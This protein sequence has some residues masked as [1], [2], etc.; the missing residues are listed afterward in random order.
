MEEKID[1]TDLSDEKRIITTYYDDEKTKI[2]KCYVADENIK[3]GLYEE[4]HENGKIALSLMCRDDKEEG[5]EVIETLYDE[6]G[7]PVSRIV[8]HDEDEDQYIADVLESRREGESDKE[9][10]QRVC[11]EHEAKEQE[12]RLKRELEESF[13]RAEEEYA[14][15]YRG[16]NDFDLFL[17]HAD[18]DPKVPLEIPSFSEFWAVRKK[19]V[20][21]IEKA[22]AEIAEAEARDQWMQQDENSLVVY[23]ED[24]LAKKLGL[25]I[26]NLSTKGKI[27][28]PPMIVPKAVS[29]QFPKAIK[30]TVTQN[31][32]RE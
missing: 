9:F 20:L 8:Y 17:F 11:V 19:Q 5:K 1:V 14:Q 22:N 15:R 3:V 25:R 28:K 21:W 10:M 2:H 26:D 7:N 18:V 16:V 4:Y 24:L 12:E 30:T 31:D 29:M 23:A 27:V 13:E 32:T 6:D